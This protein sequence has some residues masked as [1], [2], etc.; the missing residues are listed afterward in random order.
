MEELTKHME[1]EIS[2]CMLFDDD[3]I[4]IDETRVL[5]NAK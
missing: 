5:V 2:W 3:I 4:L 1:E